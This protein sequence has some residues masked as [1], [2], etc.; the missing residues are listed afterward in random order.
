MLDCLQQRA[1]Q[2]VLRAEEVGLGD[3]GVPDFRQPDPEQLPL[4]VPLIEG[5]AGVDTLV[6]LQPVQGR[7]QQIGQGLRRLGLAHARLAFKQDGL[8]QPDGQEQRGGQ[9]DVGKVVVAVERRDQGLDVG[10]P[11][12]DVFL[13]AGAGRRAHCAPSSP[14][15]TR[16]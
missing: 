14:A 11:P 13:R 7:V 15:R 5:L 3:R 12:L 10:N 8:W 6:A 4:V 1:A 2:Q 9:P 16:R